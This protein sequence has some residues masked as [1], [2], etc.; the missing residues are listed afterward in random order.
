MIKHLAGIFLLI[1][2]AVIPATAMAKINIFTCEPEWASL[3]AEIGGDHVKADSATHAM[4]NP[5]YIRAR[6]SLIAR[7]TKADMI[8]C[9]GGGL[10]EGWLPILLQRA[11]PALQPGKPGYL[12][13]TDH[14]TM[15]ERPQELDRSHGHIHPAGNPHVHLNPYHI[16]TIADILV[17]RFSAIDPDNAAEYEA[18]HQQFSEA[19]QKAITRWEQDA[20]PLKGMPVVVHHLSF[21]YLLN[22]LDMRQVASMEPKP[23]LPPTPSHLESL[24]QQLQQ[25]PAK[26]IIRTPYEPS[27]ASEWLSERADIPALVLPYT[28]GGSEEVNDL[29]SLFERSIDILKTVHA[30]E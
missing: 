18:R 1:G 6:P 22:W 7:V 19:W 26:A 14:M 12:M 9:S 17:E 5:H 20:I 21:S 2:L 23:G 15:L 25:E 10:E 28:V 13:A 24:L 29:F 30:A 11:P 3:A 4:Q 16:A 27:D 8:I